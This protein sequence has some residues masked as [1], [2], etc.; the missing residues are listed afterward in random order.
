[1]LCSYLIFIRCFILV[2]WVC[3][4]NS[5]VEFLSFWWMSVVLCVWMYG[6][7]GLLSSELLLF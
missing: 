1:M 3:F 5:S 4:V 6:V 7:S 2:V